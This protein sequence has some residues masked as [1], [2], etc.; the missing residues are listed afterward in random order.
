MMFETR[1]E[2]RG[3][4]EASRSVYFE[5]LDYGCITRKEVGARRL[6]GSFGLCKTLFK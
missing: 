4:A 6:G 3:Y 5:I 2:F 1:D